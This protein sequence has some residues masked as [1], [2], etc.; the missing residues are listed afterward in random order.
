MHFAFGLGAFISPLIANP[1]LLEA[2][3]EIEQFGEKVAKDYNSFMNMTYDEFRNI[4]HD[5]EEHRIAN[6]TAD[7]LKVHWAYIIISI[8]NASVLVFFMIVYC[9]RPVTKEHPSGSLPTP[10]ELTPEKSNKHDAYIIAEKSTEKSMEMQKSM[11]LHRSMELQR[12]VEKSNRINNEKHAPSA[13]PQPIDKFTLIEP[14][15]P[16]LKG[17]VVVLSIL[18][19]HSYCGLEISFGS[20]LPTFAVKSNIQMS[21]SE[22]AYLT[23]SYWG[24]FTFFRIVSLFAITFFSPRSLLIGSMGLIVLSNV[25]LLPFGNDFRW[26]LWTGSVLMGLGE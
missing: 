9:V 11:D 22:A 20:L 21:K 23:S 14:L 4:S 25:F 3:G 24:M 15:A 17:V 5:H 1:F 18:F 2:T 19:F 6:F 26:A 13:L 7:D 12:S 8:F 16:W 10:S